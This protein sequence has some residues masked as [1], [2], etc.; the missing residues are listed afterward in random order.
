MGTIVVVLSSGM[1]AL[2][3]RQFVFSGF[4]GSV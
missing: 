3:V 1:A 2:L 4:S